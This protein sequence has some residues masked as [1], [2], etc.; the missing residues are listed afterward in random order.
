MW[1]VM[2]WGVAS[3]AVLSMASC[4]QSRSE[5]YDCKDFVMSPSQYREQFAGRPGQETQQEL[6]FICRAAVYGDA[7]ATDARMAQERAADPAVKAFAAQ[8]AETQSR[9]NQRLDRVAIQ[10]EGVTPPRGLDASALAARDR[11]A[12]LSGNAF[13]RAYLQKT[14]QDGTAAA[15]LFRQGSAL[16]EPFLASFAAEALPALE[17]RVA[18]AQSLLRQ[19]GS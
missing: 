12:S 1:R 17:Q 4:A 18:Q 5:A 16:T 14:A 8:I 11:L 15:A 13:D 3:L 10:Q 6:D 2:G 9:M 7:Q 19:P